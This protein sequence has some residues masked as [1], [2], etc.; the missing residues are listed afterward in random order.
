MLIFRNI[1]Y[2]QIEMFVEFPLWSMAHVLHAF[3]VLIRTNELLTTGLKA[4]ICIK[5]LFERY[6]PAGCN[7]NGY[8]V[9]WSKANP[10][11]HWHIFLPSFSLHCLFS[12]FYSLRASHTQYTYFIS[13]NT[14]FNFV[15]TGMLLCMHPLTFASFNLKEFTLLCDRV[16]KCLNE[17]WSILYCYK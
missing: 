4:S 14:L 5:S 16:F 10:C 2:T 6:V 8:K 13:C 9:V 3:L 7:S 1:Y 11:W 17:H 12:I 15:G